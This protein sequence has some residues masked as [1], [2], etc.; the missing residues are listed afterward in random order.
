MFRRCCFYKDQSL[1]D[2][3]QSLHLE[4]EQTKHSLIKLHFCKQM[5]YTHL[6]PYLYL[7]LVFK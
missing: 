4:A 7:I 6:P 1:L 2:Y 3:T 5:V